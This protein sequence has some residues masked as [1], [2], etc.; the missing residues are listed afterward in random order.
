MRNECSHTHKNLRRICWLSSGP[1]A[2]NS[3]K[4]LEILKKFCKVDYWSLQSAPIEP[5][6]A[7]Q[8]I[9]PYR[10]FHSLTQ[11]PYLRIIKIALRTTS[12][13]TALSNIFKVDVT[14]WMR[15]IL[16]LYYTA[17]S[18]H[19]TSNLPIGVPTRPCGKGERLL[20]EMECEI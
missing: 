5:R 14:C 17:Y 8:P 9:H 1:N 16:L 20:V 18:V 13:F 4:I 11:P 7:P 6:S 19:R 15:H 2:C 10:P 3:M 12:P